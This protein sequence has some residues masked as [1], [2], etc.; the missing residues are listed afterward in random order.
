MLIGGHV[1]SSGGLAHALE[2]AETLGCEAM[3]IFNQ[4]PRAWRPTR[5]KTDD[6]DA[7]KDARRN[8]PVAVVVI[9]AVYLINCASND[10]EIRAK[11]LAS[12]THALCVGDAIEADGVVVHPGS[13]GKAAETGVA[14]KRIG[15]AFKSAIESSERCSLLLEN[16]AGGGATIGRNFDELAELIERIGDGDRLGVCLDSCHLHVSGHEIRDAKALASVVDDFD[17]VVGLERLRCLHLNDSKTAFGS[18]SDR[19][20]NLGEGELGEV[21]VRTFLGEPR[22]EGL[23][24]LLEVPGPDGHGPDKGQIDVAKR[25]R[26]EAH[27]GS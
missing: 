19:H 15:D 22:F 2:R 23:P 21:G 5:Y 14:M 27:A 4:S 6:I 18:N 20:A 26:A 25:L 12:L 11:S 10:G 13:A 1:S 9:H 24:V 3:Q 16:T 8:S 17:R 7:F